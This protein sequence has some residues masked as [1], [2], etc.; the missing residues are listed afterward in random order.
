M[1]QNVKLQR[2]RAVVREAALAANNEDRH[3]PRHPNRELNGR[4]YM[5][6]LVRWRNRKETGRYGGN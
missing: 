4:R 2:R 5:K 3:E 6:S 1:R